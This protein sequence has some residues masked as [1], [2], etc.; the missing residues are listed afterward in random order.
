MEERLL[1]QNALLDLSGGELGDGLGALRDGVLGELTGEDESDGG[2]D[3]SGRESALLGVSSELGGLRSDSIKDIVDERVHDA[4]ASLGDTGIGVDLLEDLVDVR[5]VSLGS[6]RLSGG[7][8]LFG[9]LG[10]FLSRGLDHGD[11]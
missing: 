10:Y 11:E 7:A 5:R 8:S 2:L 1:V 4:H 6:L 3:L 9:G